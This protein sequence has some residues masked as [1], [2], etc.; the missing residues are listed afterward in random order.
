[1]PHNGPGNSYAGATSAS[2][3]HAVAQAADAAAAAALAGSG[4]AAMAG[5][6]DTSG[7]GLPPPPLGPSLAGPLSLAPSQQGTASQQQ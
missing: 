5:N 4:D 2:A 3:V 1:M 6:G 7:L